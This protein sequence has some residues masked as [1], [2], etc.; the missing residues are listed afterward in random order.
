M[1]Q[2]GSD[3]L[4]ALRRRLSRWRRRHGGPGRRIPGWVWTEAA[5]VARTVGVQETAQVLRLA[6][7]RLESGLRA[8]SSGSGSGSAFVELEIGDLEMVG[9]VTV[10]IEQR[11][12]PRVRVHG[13]SADAVTRV[14][15]SML[16]LLQ[17]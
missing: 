11:D 15:A 5:T 17:S 8:G 4:G 9:G 10:E 6:P 2:S 16:G 14:A 13:A 1:P 12:G 7:A 3:A